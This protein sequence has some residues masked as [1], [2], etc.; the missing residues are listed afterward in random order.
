MSQ[1]L[2]DLNWK[3][4][5][6]YFAQ[7]AAQPWTEWLKEV[8]PVHSATPP[9]EGGK[10]RVALTDGKQG[11]VG[12]LQHPGNKN[13]TCLYKISKADDNLVE[14]EY[15]ILKG[16]EPLAQY[17][18]HFHRA[19]GIL[20]FDCN[21]HLD[22]DR[23]LRVNRKSKVVQRKML[24]MQRITHV[25]NLHDLIEDAKI[26]DDLV[27][28][29]IKQTLICI[30][31]AQTYRCTHY[32]LHSENILVRQCNPNLHLLYV[33]DDATEILLPT[34]GYLVNVIDF[35]FAYCDVPENALTCT[36]VHTRQGFTSARF[37]PYA[38]LKLFLVSVT[39]DFT[40]CD[41]QRKAITR[42][43]TNITRN[44]FEG[45]NIRWSSGWDNSKLTNPVQMVHEL[46]KEYVADSVLFTKTDV[47]FD[48]LQ[49]LITLPLSPLPYHDLERSCRGFIGEF[50]KF[51]ERIVSKT[52]L[53]YVLG[54]LV[55]H[56]REYRHSF[57]KSG[58]EGAWALLEI[59][60]HFLDEYTQLISYHVPSIDYEK[61]VC[62][63]LVMTDCIEG[64]FHDALER[65]YAEKDK[66][67][68]IMRCRTPLEFYQVMDANFPLESRK[69]FTT[70]STVMVVDHVTR[71]SKL[72][73]LN[74]EHVQ[75]LGRLDDPGRRARYLRNLY[76]ASVD[77]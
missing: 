37:D 15:K 61:L 58:E 12:I 36:L 71:Q 51:E 53:N 43:M 7:H 42:K 65:R 1:S 14:H 50:V 19:Y 47:W 60:K 70:K 28:N 68:E 46:I 32:D 31:L 2:F 27:L 35:G 38:D 44:V 6:Q 74:G 41:T 18:P 55:K 45:M 30:H 25:G 23:P 13:Q 73:H 16:L 40:R 52:L 76:Q 39:D 22:T 21:V 77:A 3:Q 64:L 72:L 26:K 34:F 49:L 11:Y 33:L 5:A 54:L 63:L 75:V 57:C 8:E 10:R 69:A 62:S 67:Y 29:L 56:V 48:T 17:C 20:P 66:Q 9:E 24:L 4:F 59:K